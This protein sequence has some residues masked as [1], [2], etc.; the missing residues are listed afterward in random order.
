MGILCGLAQIS[1][2]AAE[3]FTLARIDQGFGTNIF[4][5]DFDRVGIYYD[6]YCSHDMSTLVQVY[7]VTTLGI[8]E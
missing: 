1:S 5:V 8:Y 4:V 6:V 2:R 3:A 7:M